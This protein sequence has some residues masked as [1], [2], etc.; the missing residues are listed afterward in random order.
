MLLGKKG[1]V[2]K[3]PTLQIDFLKNLERIP[4]PFPQILEPLLEKLSKSLEKEDYA[5]K[6]LKEYKYK[7]FKKV[8]DKNMNADKEAIIYNRNIFTSLKYCVDS[9]NS[10]KLIKT[11]RM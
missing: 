3:K 2:L 9:Y 6:E 5:L 7:P 8:L 1:Q 11:K 10:V 4:F